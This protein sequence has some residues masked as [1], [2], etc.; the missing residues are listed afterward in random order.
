MDNKP[1]SLIEENIFSFLDSHQTEGLNSTDDFKFEELEDLDISKLKDIQLRGIDPSKVIIVEDESILYG[2][3]IIE[4]VN[5]S[6]ASNEVDVYKRFLSDG[7]GN[8]KDSSGDQEN[9]K[10]AV[11]KMSKYIGDNLLEIIRLS[12]KHFSF[13]DLKLPEDS[14]Y[15]IKSIL[16]NKIK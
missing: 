13:K 6:A 7:G 15:S 8:G 10:A 16:Y 2:Y 11:E 5:N 4:D 12:N 14:L 9:T 1:S 3:I